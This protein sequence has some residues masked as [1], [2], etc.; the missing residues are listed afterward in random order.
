MEQTFY[1]I[2]DYYI[3][4]HGIKGQKWGLRRYQNS[5]GTLTEEG[6][7]HYAKSFEKRPLTKREDKYSKTLQNEGMSKE[8][9]DA[10]ARRRSN[11]LKWTAVGVGA[12]AVAS[13]AAHEYKKYS[14]E[15]V[16][17]IIKKDTPI[18]TLSFD[19]DRMSKGNAFYT[20]Y[21]QKDKTRYE[22]L[23]GRRGGQNKFAITRTA[24]EDVKI[25]SPKT[26]EETF[27]RLMK[28]GS[29]RK[30]VEK[31]E[32]IRTKFETGNPWRHQQKS[33]SLYDSFNRW[34]LIENEDKHAIKSQ[35]Q[36][37]KALKKQGYGGVVD[38]NDLKYT[39]IKTDPVIVFAKNKFG[40]QSVSQLTSKRVY[41]SSVKTGLAYA[42]D[43]LNT[44]LVN[45]PALAGAAYGA[46]IIA[47][48][49]DKKRANKEKAKR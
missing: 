42:A 5:D 16:D 4:H 21:N 1:S 18:Q 27:N 32:G 25:A 28:K 3:S 2:H 33:K 22:G 12:V 44:P 7:R 6:K 31:T 19:K 10:T 17:R 39:G 38:T 24:T 46:S 35:K 47:K 13:I 8:D 23:F 41:T 20:A 37:Y 15:N 34:N 9:A 45:V 40:N 14:M 36:F 29:F 48:R 26:A 30:N 43:V 11:L 49:R